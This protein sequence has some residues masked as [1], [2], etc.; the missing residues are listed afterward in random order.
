M[1]PNRK[2]KLS[3]NSIHEGVEVLAHMVQPFK[4]E[5]I[6]GI[7]RG[8]LIPA[9]L[10]SHALGLPMSVVNVKAY[11]GT[12]RTLQK[13]IVT[14]WREAYNKPTTIVIDDIM[15]TGASWD[16]ILYGDGRLGTMM[17]ANLAT[18]VKK[19]KA[20][21]TKHQ[22]FFMQVPPEVWVQFPWEGEEL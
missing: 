9:T 14:D 11:E 3:W 7:S 15:D 4:P 1:E 12:R 21:F 19:T 8:G 20:A 6:V 16:A 22:T 17:Q 5:L 18:L 13:P 2:L 10:L